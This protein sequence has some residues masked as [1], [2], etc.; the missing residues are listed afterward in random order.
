MRRYT[1]RRVLLW[2]PLP[3][4]RATCRPGAPRALTPKALTGKVVDFGLAKAEE[5]DS[6]STIPE[7]SL[8]LGTQTGVILA[9][10]A[11]MSP[12]QAEG[13]KLDGRSDIFSF[14][15][16]LYEM[17]TGRRPFAGPP[18]LARLSELNISQR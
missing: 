11:Y 6:A 18:K 5:S 12:E 13:E 8:T 4:P 14:G 2:S 1:R 7:N 3:K 15:T 16:V 17:T 10:A 9:T